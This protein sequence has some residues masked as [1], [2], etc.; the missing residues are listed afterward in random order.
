MQHDDKGLVFISYSHRDIQWRDRL[1]VHLTPLMRSDLLEFWDDRKISPGELWNETI[2]NALDKA[3]VVVAL[4]TGDFLASKYIM[5]KEIRTVLTRKN[6]EKG[7]KRLILVNIKPSVIKLHPDLKEFQCANAISEPIAG[8]NEVEQEAAFVNVVKEII[9]S[10]GE[11]EHLAYQSAG[12]EAE[13]QIN[14]GLDKEELEFL[15]KNMLGHWEITHL[16]KLAVKEQ[17]SY[18][19]G[20]TFEN[21]LSNLLKMQMIDRHPGK[22]IRTALREGGPGSNLHWHFFVTEKGFRYLGIIEKLGIRLLQPV[23]EL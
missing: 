7:K 20:K 14:A 13:R 22:G 18:L 23:G 17:F 4:V 19:P 9:D 11:Q 3:A 1:V 15:E 10:L 12:N 6:H 2:K 5:E 8:L 21:E 16:R